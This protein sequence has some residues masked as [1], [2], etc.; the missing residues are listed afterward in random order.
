MMVGDSIENDIDG[1]EQAGI[2]AVLI[3]RGKIHSGYTGTKI[4]AL[5]EVIP[6]L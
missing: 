6:L 1:A 2:K 5:S 3:D 4:G